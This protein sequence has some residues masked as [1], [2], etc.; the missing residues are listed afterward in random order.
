M[1]RCLHFIVKLYYSGGCQRAE[2][3]MR[4]CGLLVVVCHHAS[5][6]HLHGPAQSESVQPRVQKS[7]ILRQQSLKPST[8]SFWARGPVMTGCTPM[9]MALEATWV[10]VKESL[11]IRAGSGAQ[12]LSNSSPRFI[13]GET[14]TQKGQVTCLKVAEW[15]RGRTWIGSW[16]SQLGDVSYSTTRSPQP[17]PDI[18]VF[19]PVGAIDLQRGQWWGAVVIGFKCISIV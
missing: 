6:R 3:V 12:V 10:S 14:E 4:I 5:L 7:R 2:F 13:D 17:W 11:N 8:G 16:A 19:L 9:E 18:C 1:F 15:V